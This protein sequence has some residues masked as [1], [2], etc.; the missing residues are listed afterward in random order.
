MTDQQAGAPGA[1]HVSSTEAGVINFG[2]IS[3][4]VAGGV[5]SQ[6][7]QNVTGGAGTDDRLARLEA[8]LAQLAADA[9]AELDGG[10]ADQVSDDT[11]RIAD[12]IARPRPDRDRITQL[13]GRLTTVVGS[14]AG[15]LAAVDRI[16][17]LVEAIFH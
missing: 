6:V 17:D 8:A 2:S 7:T 1:G 10:Q 5:R 15:L 12:E 16:K 14:A 9:A 3:G 13:L 11:A 4:P